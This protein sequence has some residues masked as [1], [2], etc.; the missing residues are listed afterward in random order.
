MVYREWVFFLQHKGARPKG[1]FPMKNEFVGI[2]NDQ[3]LAKTTETV[4]LEKFY[5]ARLISA[6]PKITSHSC[7]LD[8]IVPLRQR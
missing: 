6:R 4:K 3:L 5:A 1:N 2:S 8:F 7:R